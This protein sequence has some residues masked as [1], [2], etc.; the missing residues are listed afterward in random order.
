MAS[1]F[2][3][4]KF[5]ETTNGFVQVIGFTAHPDIHGNLTGVRYEVHHGRHTIGTYASQK[6]AETVAQ[7]IAPVA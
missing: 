2:Y 5:G 1:E 4:K 7:A 3:R 6:E